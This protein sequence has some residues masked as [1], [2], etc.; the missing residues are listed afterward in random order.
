M[1]RTAL[2]LLAIA[3]AGCPKLTPEAAAPPASIEFKVDPKEAYS[4]ALRAVVLADLAV[5]MKDAD[6]GVVQTEWHL[7]DQQV[8]VGGRVERRVRFKIIA[9]DGACVVKPQTERRGIGTLGGVEVG[10]WKETQ[11]LTDAEKAAFDK[12]RSAISAEL[13]KP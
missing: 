10:P 12:L 11:G 3:L 7:S 2:L 13:S 8:G 1:K 4:R 9:A 6:A 5:E